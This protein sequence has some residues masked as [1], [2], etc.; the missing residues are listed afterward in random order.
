[1]YSPCFKNYDNLFIIISNNLNRYRVR[2]MSGNKKK[3]F[4]QIYLHYYFH[5]IKGLHRNLHL[6]FELPANKHKKHE[7]FFTTKDMNPRLLMQINLKKI[8]SSVSR[9]TI[10]SRI[11]EKI[12]RIMKV[13]C[14][15]YNSR[16]FS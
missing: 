7:I 16:H 14:N 4:F 3:I 13:I 12:S 5:A 6:I 11:L 8:F 15:F 10:T 1:M 2:R 9:L